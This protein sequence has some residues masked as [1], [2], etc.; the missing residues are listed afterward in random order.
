MKGRMTEI[1]AAI[2]IDEVLIILVRQGRP[3][4]MQSF[5]NKLKEYVSENG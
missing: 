2:A 1:R 3:P 5:P 4:E